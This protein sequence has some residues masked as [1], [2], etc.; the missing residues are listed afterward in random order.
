M[1]IEAVPPPGGDNVCAVVV[2]YF[3]DVDLLSRVDR[4]V[5][6][7]AGTL[8]VDN[9]SPELYVE[10]LRGIASQLNIH[11]ILNS[12]NQGIAQALNTGAAWALRHGYSWL[13]TLDQ[14]TLI[15]PGLIQT[16]AEAFR[17]DPFPGRLAVIGSN[18][19][20]KVTKRLGNQGI[21]GPG[22]LAGKSMISVLTSGS[23]VSLSVFQ[24]LGG[25]R[26]DFFIDCVDHEYCLRARGR[27]FRVVMTREPVME[28]GIGHL[29]EHQL[30]WKTFGASNHSPQRQY[31]IARNSLLLVRA[32][33]GQE[34]RWILGYLW[35]WV[36]LVIR[37]FL[38]EQE[39]LAK[40]KN[41]VRGL[42]DGILGRTGYF[43][44]KDSNLRPTGVDPV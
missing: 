26:E 40:G 24:T 27:G 19:I 10:R 44:A 33:L 30:L 29:T 34:P 23:L 42:I 3:P 16:H 4:V 11:L 15:F 9:G 14:D 31:Y 28:H 39:R 5:K 6:Q 41:V 20:H 37:I 12:C 32:Y 1:T 21:T 43:A 8:I 13:L 18:Y 35:G 25:F 2:T 17:C 38:F 36:K 7:V 22:Q